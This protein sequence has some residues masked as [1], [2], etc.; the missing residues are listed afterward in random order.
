MAFLAVAALPVAMGIVILKYHLYV[1]VVSL[2]TRVLPFSSPMGVAVSTLAVAAL[3]NP[4]RRR[5][6]RA[7]NRRFNRARYDHEATVATFGARLKDAVNLD[8]VR[9]D[10]TGVVHRALEPAHVSG[11]ISRRG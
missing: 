7:V 5:V 4:L 6:Q 3:F 10:L 8:A 11:L 2:A 1:G 9:E